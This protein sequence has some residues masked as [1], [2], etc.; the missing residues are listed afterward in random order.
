MLLLVLFL[1]YFVQVEA[2]ID[3]CNEVIIS[4]EADIDICIDMCNEVIVSGEADIDICI[5][6]CNEVIVSDETEIA[7][8]INICPDGEFQNGIFDIEGYIKEGTITFPSGKVQNGNF[9]N[10][11]LE[12]GYISY[13]NKT[14]LCVNTQVEKE[15]KE[16][17][18][19][20]TSL[21]IINEFKIINLKQE[22]NRHQETYEQLNICED[23]KIA[24]TIIIV[25]AIIIFV[26]ICYSLYLYV[27]K[28][29]KKKNIN[30]KKQLKE[31]DDYDE[32]I[33][34]LENEL[35]IIKEKKKIITP[36][37]ENE[38]KEL[39]MQLDYANQQ[40]E[41][42]KMQLDCAYQ[43]IEELKKE[44]ELV[45]N[46]PT[47]ASKEERKKAAKESKKYKKHNV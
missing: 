15:L 20:L 46:T 1:S 19:E 40:I 32:S 22:Q 9:V 16:K 3:I 4:D 29:K 38:N 13:P 24:L 2:D 8:A 33:K 7:N 35:N 26:G 43:K 14:I 34:K 28:L 23:N 45:Q 25:I 39:K 30:L 31:R 5:D 44:N 21:K 36:L 17:D 10:G 27:G 37:L 42:Q 47:L 41:K 11:T 6:K 12:K 18:D